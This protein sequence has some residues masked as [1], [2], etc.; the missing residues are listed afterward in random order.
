MC[1]LKLCKSNSD[2]RQSFFNRLS[3]SH[4]LGIYIIE[5]FDFRYAVTYFLLVRV[6]NLNRTNT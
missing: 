5:L 6:E 1:E 3:M 2:L 4:I